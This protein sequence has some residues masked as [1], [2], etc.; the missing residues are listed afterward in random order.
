MFAVLRRPQTDAERALVH[1]AATDRY[2]R[3]PE[4]LRSGQRP[5]PRPRRARPAGIPLSAG[6]VGLRLLP[7]CR[8]RRHHVPDGGQARLSA[9]DRRAR[10]PDLRARP[11]RRAP[12]RRLVPGRAGL[13]HSSETTSGRRARAARRRR[14]SSGRTPRAARSTP[15]TR[16][17][18]SP[19][20][21]ERRRRSR[22]RPPSSMSTSTSSAATASAS[23]PPPAATAMRSRCTAGDPDSTAPSRSRCPPDGRRRSRSSSRQP[24]TSAP[25]VASSPAKSSSCNLRKPAPHATVVA[26]HRSTS[27]SS[28]PSGCPARRSRTQSAKRSASGVSVADVA[29]PTTYSP[30]TQADDAHAWSPPLRL[31]LG[32][33]LRSD[34]HAHSL[35]GPSCTTTTRRR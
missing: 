21:A 9:H 7:G 13:A 11:R 16:A 32:L 31:A 12:S 6:I 15:H 24:A 17:A 20:R 4:V 18:E 8:G 27:S 35:A 14:R 1:R 2:S 25:A 5:H 34:D 29:Q 10:Q 26:A 28:A 30:M 33:R 3:A 19:A 23:R 22:S